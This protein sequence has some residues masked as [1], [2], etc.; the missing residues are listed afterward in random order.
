MITGSYATIY[1]NISEYTYCA[2]IV[3]IRPLSTKMALD[4]IPKAYIPMPN[5]PSL[6][7]FCRT[8]P[9][10]GWRRRPLLRLVTAGSGGPGQP[11][12]GTMTGCPSRAGRGGNEGGRKPAG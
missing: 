1:I 11:S 2:N 7:A 9:D 4:F 6:G 8:L 5:H 12:A 10:V 3:R